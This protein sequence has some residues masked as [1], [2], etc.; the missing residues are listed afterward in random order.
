MNSF[1]ALKC[2]NSAIQNPGFCQNPRILQLD[3]FDILYSFRLYYKQAG[4]AFY[5]LEPGL[6]CR[7]SFCGIL[8]FKTATLSQIVEMRAVF[9]SVIK[10]GRGPGA[11]NPWPAAREYTADC[12]QRCWTMEAGR[13]TSGEEIGIPAICVGSWF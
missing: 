12:E 8:S 6:F 10:A 7:E 1:E 3:L 5:A 9:D 2:V 11:R 13:K 4:S